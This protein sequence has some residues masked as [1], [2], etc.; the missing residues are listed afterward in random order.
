MNATWKAVVGILLVFVL[1]W[2]GGALTTAIIIRHKAL[3][4]VQRGPAAILLM[5][6]RQTTRSLGLNESQKSQLHALMEKNVQQR[7]ELQKQ[8]QPQVQAINRETLQEIDALLTPDQQQRFRDNLIRFK[9][10]F[11]RNPFNVD[12][13]SEV[14]APKSVGA[15]TNAPAVTK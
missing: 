7:F 13:P 10:R 1:G 4:T 8:I 14:G 15:G 9:D 2:L 6:E 11:G 12:A 3:V 5:L